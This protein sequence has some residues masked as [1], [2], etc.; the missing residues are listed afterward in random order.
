ML[1]AQT[2]QTV[3]QF[4]SAPTVSTTTLYTTVGIVVVVVLVGVF[5]TLRRRDRKGAVGPA[6]VAA[7]SPPR[8]V[9]EIS[10]E[11]AEKLQKLG[12]WDQ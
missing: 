11:T 4:L 5:L 12:C 9:Q 1:T 8:A 10:P 7:I 3:L 6:P 2:S